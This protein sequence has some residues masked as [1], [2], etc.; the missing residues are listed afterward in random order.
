[1]GDEC[2]PSYSVVFF[3]RGGGAIDI[4]LTPT[5]VT[6]GRRI[7]DISAATI[8]YTIGGDNCCLELGI[9][10]PLAHSVGIYR[11]GKLAWFGWIYPRVTYGFGEVTIEAVDGLWWL[12]RRI[13]H[14]DLSWKNTDLVDIFSDLYDDAMAPDPISQLTVVKTNTNVTESRIAKA[15]DNRYTWNIVKEMLDTGLDVTAFGKTIIAGLIVNS[16]KVQLRM[17]D[18]QGDPKIVKD[19]GQFADR[20]IVDASDK[21]VGIWPPGQ[22]QATGAYPLVELVLKDGQIQDAASALNAAK[23]RYEF[24]R[25]VPRQITLGDGIILLPNSAIN[26]GN[27]IPGTIVTVDTEG[28]CYQQKEDFRVGSIDVTV[29]AGNETV[30]MSLQPTGPGAT[31]AD[32]EEPVF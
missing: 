30:N 28:L 14:N 21:A 24:S 20:V 32:V 26:V 16:G 19:G 7:D 23:A 10:E 29:A 18:V 2:N 8:V 12:T 15:K 6:W 13:V 3:N 27:L 4:P 11:N 1:M 25:R 31:L 17:R 22:P 9:L 5:S